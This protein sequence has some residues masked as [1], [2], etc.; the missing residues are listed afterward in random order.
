LFGNFEENNLYGTINSPEYDREDM[1]D[2]SIAIGLIGKDGM[3]LA[4]DSCLISLIPSPEGAVLTRNNN[5]KKLWCISDVMGVACAS[6]IYGW[7]TTIIERFEKIKNSLTYGELTRELADCVTEEIN[8][9]KLSK[10]AEI[11]GKLMEFLIM[12]YDNSIP[13]I[14]LIHWKDDEQIAPLGT[15]SQN[16]YSIGF[17]MI[18]DYWLKKIDPYLPSMGIQELKK[19]AS[20]LIYESQYFYTVLCPI[21]MVTIQKNEGIKLILEPELHRLETDSMTFLNDNVGLLLRNLQ[22]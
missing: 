20:F 21:E 5:A 3:V 18:A 4:T 13:K 11:K 16:S 14:N 8:N 12:G 2:M 6:R 9:A 1:T 22:K 19:L 10:S 7:E 15:I 17:P